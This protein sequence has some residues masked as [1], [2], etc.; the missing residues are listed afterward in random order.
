MLL[1]PYAM[2]SADSAGRKHPEPAA[3]LSRARINATATASCTAP[4]FAG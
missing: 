4:R 1:A 3:S 2:H